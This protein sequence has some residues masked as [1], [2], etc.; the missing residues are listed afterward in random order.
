M[1]A[2]WQYLTHSE[3]ATCDEY[4][5]HTLYTSHAGY[6]D[7]V[8]K[9]RKAAWHWLSDRLE[10]LKTDGKGDKHAEDRRQ[11]INSIVNGDNRD[12]HNAGPNYPQDHLTDQESVHVREREQYC[13]YSDTY[14]GL[15]KRDSDNFHWLEGRRK[16][17]WRDAEGETDSE[18][19]PG[20]DV[21]SRKERYDNI[22]IAT[23][24][25]SAYDDWCKTHDPKT[26]K[27]KNG[28]GGGSGGGSSRDKAISWQKS[29]LSITEDPTNSNCDS[30]SDGIRK[31][32]DTCA[33]GGTWLRYQPWCGVWCMNALRAAGVTGLDSNL[34]S[35]AWIEQQAKAGKKPFRGWTTDGS[36]AKAGDLVVLFGSGQHVGMVDEVH[37][38]SVETYEG[39]TSVGSNGGSAHKSRSRSSDT[40]GY[41][42]VAFP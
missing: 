8:T 30:R 12:V 15:Q 13:A 25:G 4:T 16:E 3:Q 2:N 11:H 9:R 6:S 5:D 40:Y 26:G 14:D 42:L 17:I 34:A 19:G 31:A 32:Q 23:H 36:K 18:Y 21:R 37:S 10:Y 27:P 28:G 24:Y 1:T 20:W 22:A 29:H 38:D 33:G 35:V 39:N 41:A 7:D